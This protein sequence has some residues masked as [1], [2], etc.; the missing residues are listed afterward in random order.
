[1][2]STDQN[3]F[4]LFLL[5]FIPVTVGLWL[6]ASVVGAVFDFLRDKQ[7]RDARKAKRDE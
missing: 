7:R 5:F 2:P 4:F 6:M 1:M 3:G